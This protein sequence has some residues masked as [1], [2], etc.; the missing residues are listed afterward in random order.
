MHTVN[1]HDA[2]THFSRLI[3]DALSGKETIIAKAGKPA[4][5]LVPIKNNPPR[6]FGVL[7]G[8]IHIANDF[9]E[10]LSND[11]INSFED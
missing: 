6:R 5:K 4:A 9:D 7:K 11:I 1:I 10:P 8:K 2:K 3:E